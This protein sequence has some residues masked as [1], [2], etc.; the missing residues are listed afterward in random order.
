MT[1]AGRR[2]WVMA[3]GYSP[4]E[5]GHQTYAEQVAAAYARVG[6]SVTVFTQTSVGPRD[7]VSGRVRL[8][9]LGVDKTPA[10]LGRWL[11]ALLRAR[12][13]EGVP[14]VLHATTWRTSVPPMLLGIPF[15]VTVHG[16][17]IMYARRVELA[18]LRRVARTARCVVAVSHYTSARLVERVPDLSPEPIVVWNG[19]TLAT[20]RRRESPAVPMILTLCRLEPR[21]NVPGAL[22]GVEIARRRGLRFRYVI[23][24]RGPDHSRVVDEVRR[25]GLG[26][27]VDIAGFVSNER[28]RELYSQ[29]DIFLHPQLAI[30][31]GRDFEGFGIAIADAML[32]GAAVIVGDEGGSPELVE[33]GVSGLLVDGRSPDSIADAIEALLRDD[34]RR[35]SIA[36]AGRARAET[37]M[38]WDRHV[39]RVIEALCAR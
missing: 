26:D 38:T 8:V 24:G 22:A 29:A 7:V 6:A 13:S 16:R 9:D 30:D 19:A 3:K 35:R 4:D 15:V 17:E 12:S 10:A 37:S 2:V 18:I 39:A 5:G 27:I 31:A 14:S 25:R 20:P 36:F 11:I 32:A 34:A 28:A 1:L 23:C 21:K 33:D